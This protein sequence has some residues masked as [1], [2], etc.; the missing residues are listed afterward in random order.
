MSSNVKEHR[1][2]SVAELQRF[3]REKTRLTFLLS[4]NDRI[5]G[6]LR[7]FDE[8]C[9]SLEESEGEVTTLIRGSVISYKR[10]K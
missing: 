8:H 3:I 2:P 9:F 4:N 5:S 6:S 10:Q 7:W 1:A